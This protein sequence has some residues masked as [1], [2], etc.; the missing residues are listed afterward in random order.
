MTSE[1]D[2]GG[3]VGCGDIAISLEFKNIIIA[4]WTKLLPT[5]DAT[6]P[7]LLDLGLFPPLPKY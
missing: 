3:G 5:Q 7:K 4:Q 6:L 1:G 2:C